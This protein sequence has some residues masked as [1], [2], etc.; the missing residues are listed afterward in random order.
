MDSTV[1][2]GV[3]ALSQAAILLH[4]GFGNELGVLVGDTVAA[5]VV[6]LGIVRSPPVAQI[7]MVVELSPL[8]VVTMDGL[9]PDDRAGGRIIYRVILCRIEERRLQ[10]TRREIDGVGLGILI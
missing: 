10:N 1:V 4:A 5:F 9:V 2:S 6:G 8:I 3:L 7:A